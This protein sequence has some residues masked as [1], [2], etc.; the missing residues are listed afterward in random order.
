LSLF[1]ACQRL[2]ENPR[3]GHTREDL[4]NQPVLFLPVGSYLIIYDPESK[5]LSIVRI[6]HGARD[7]HSL[8]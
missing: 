6:V 8:F 5:P 2:A 7:V 3:I 1:E 4:T